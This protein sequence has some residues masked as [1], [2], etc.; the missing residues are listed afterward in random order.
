MNDNNRFNKT[1]TYL[2]LQQGGLL[3]ERWYSVDEIAAH[4]GVVRET[5]YRWIDRQG[6]PAH[7]VGRLWKFKLPEVDEWVRAEPRTDSVLERDP[8]LRRI[9][10][11]LVGALQPVRIYLFGSQARGEGGIESDYDLVVLVE[12]PGEPRYR[13]SQVGYRALRDIP[14]AVDVVV[15]DR[16]TFD[17]RVHLE[18]SFPASVI[19]EGK[20]LYAA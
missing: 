18:A 9:V 11:H 5:V 10:E 19:R 1:I 17:A 2:L 12:R 4:L 15:W 16:A 6:M 7:R 20:V 14:A 13:L 3:A 8:I